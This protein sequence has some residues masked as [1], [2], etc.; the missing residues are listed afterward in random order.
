MKLS[1]PIVKEI[2]SIKVISKEEIGIS[3]KKFQ[4]II[5][6][7]VQQVMQPS[8]MQKGI[9]IAGSPMYMNVNGEQNPKEIKFE[10]CFPVSGIPTVEKG[11]SIKDIPA[12]KVASLIMKGSY[13]NFT[14]EGYSKLYQ[15]I[16]Q[17]NYNI[18]GPLREIYMSN[19]NDT[20][21]EEAITELQV[22]IE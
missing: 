4:N 8:N 9:H 11:F 2:S 15:F 1:E 22:P 19:P 3:K 17:N 6:E 16:G 10:I 20:P 7:L 18:K 13:E 21:L 14:A 5:I 12:G